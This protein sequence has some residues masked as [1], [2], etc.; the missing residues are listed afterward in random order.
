MKRYEVR[1]PI[2]KEIQEELAPYSELLQ[3]LLYYRDITTKEAA[4]RFLNPDF[5]RDLHD[6]FLLPN[7]DAAVTRIAEAIANNEQ[8]TIYADYD[9]D[10]VPGAA[11]LSD[12]F[13]K[14]GFTNFD[15]YIPHRNREG[16]GLN[17]E[18]VQK[19]AE[20]GTTLLITIDCGIAD[21]AEVSILRERGVDVVITDHH[22]AH[23]EIPDAIIVNHKL[24]TSTYPERILCGSGVVFKLVQALIAR[25]VFTHTPGTEKW[26]LDL[27]G[28]ATLSDMVPL[29]GE[30]RALAHFGLIV[31]RKT[32]RKGLLHLFKKAGTN[33]RLITETDV[34]FSISPRINAAS[35]M[36]EPQAAFN[37]L[38]TDDDVEASEHVAH[39]HHINDMR[40]GHV[41][42]IV[43]AIH[44]RCEEKD[45]E[46]CPVIV[47]GN[48]EW[49]PSLLG[50][51]A[52]SIAEH[53]R[54]PVFLW[55]RGDGTELKGSCR[56]AN[57]I[58]TLKIMQGASHMMEAFGGHDQAGG[59]VVALDKVDLLEDAFIASY[60]AAELEKTD[61][62][63]W[64]DMY[65]RPED[66]SARTYEE[67]R[68]LAPFGVG[69]AEPT[70]I[71]Q[72]V[73]VKQ[74]EMFG[75]T[76][77]HLKLVCHRETGGDLEAISFYTKTDALTRSC[78][79]GDRRDIVA[80][81]DRNVW[82]NRQSIRLRLLDVL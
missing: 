43:K 13:R 38:A 45:L 35:R 57:G 40:K 12:F 80:T 60:H 79:P 17:K 4:E 11:I 68:K 42:A 48:P 81:L 22:E 58:S 37:M 47:M 29:V 24:K 54:R 3:T 75:K 39:L 2:P 28:I 19:I 52:N 21:A 31:L 30:N 62:P 34:G 44:K 26:L 41:A 46:A 5:D 82:G 14:N 76:K 66:V 33:Q 59:F 56:T 10:G 49:Q 61:E 7:M 8:V 73:L 32:P 9:A 77:E 50:L 18:A 51:A 23:N 74:V 65:L 64:I 70:F 71:I 25:N 55:G 63:T 72:N 27:V 15:V 20:A 67:M 1:K 69:N 16:F 53:Y 78:A 36:G 6:P